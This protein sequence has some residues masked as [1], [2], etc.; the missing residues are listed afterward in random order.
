MYLDIIILIIAVEATVE[1]FFKGSI[2]QPFRRWL[3]KHTTLFTVDDENLFSCAVC[4]SFWVAVV[5]VSTY[6][7]VSKGI[8]LF[9]L[10]LCVHRLSNWLHIVFGIIK[11]WQL[12]IRINR[13]KTF[14]E[15]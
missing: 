3:I 11:D 2:F 14:K 4:V 15:D 9:A 5:F 7:F 8:I 10:V 6:F 1:L 12:N 13:N